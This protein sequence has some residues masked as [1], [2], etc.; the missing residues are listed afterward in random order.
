MPSKAAE[1]LDERIDKQNRIRVKYLT[2]VEALR[3]NYHSNLKKIQSD[4]DAK[5][6]KSHSRQ[7][8]QE[9]NKTNGAESFTKHIL[10]SN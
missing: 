2:E 1:I 6:L 9:L 8:T 7:V 5:G 3:Q 10:D 4:L